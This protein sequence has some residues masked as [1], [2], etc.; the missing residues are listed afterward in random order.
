MR[1][2]RRRFGFD[3]L[4]RGGDACKG[5]AGPRAASSGLLAVPLMALE[6]LSCMREMAC[7]PCA[8][9]QG[10][11]RAYEGPPLPFRYQRPLLQVRHSTLSSSFPRGR[12]EEIKNGATASGLAL[13]QAHDPQHST[14]QP[15]GISG[16]NAPSSSLSTVAGSACRLRLAATAYTD[17]VSQAFV[18]GLQVMLEHVYQYLYAAGSCGWPE[19]SPC[20]RVSALCRRRVYT[21]PLAEI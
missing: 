10:A 19:R 1:I 13:F 5:P 7:S 6:L 14:Q 9:N 18:C 15:L 17:H 4:R 21:A 11:S 16:V 20:G 2:D 12:D 8:T 3:W